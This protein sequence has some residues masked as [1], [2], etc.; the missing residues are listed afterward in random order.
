[1]FFK[2]YKL[3]MKHIF[4]S[5]LVLLLMACGGSKKIVDKPIVFDQ[6]RLELTKQYLAT[7][8]GLIS[9]SPTI[10]PR[11]I[12]LHWTV[13]P[14]MQQTFDVFNPSKLPG[15]PDLANAS[16]LNVS[17][18]FLVD[19]DGTIYRLMPETTMA[20]HVIGLNH[21]AIGIENVGGTDD[22]PLTKAQI[23][24]NVWLVNYLSKKYPIEY[25]IGHYEYTNFEGHELWRESDTNYRTEKT[26][27]G[28]D[29]MNAVRKK[30]EK[31]NLRP[32][33]KK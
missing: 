12:V 15:R 3:I 24:S 5:S 9:D 27:P 32:V 30:T 21:A 6:E 4:I 1:M 20:R 29:F 23:K 33:P 2:P 25:L 7:R 19:R 8:H 18:Q 28:V 10:T 11:M 26:D 16:T 31:L 17:S 22:L 14:T 13:I